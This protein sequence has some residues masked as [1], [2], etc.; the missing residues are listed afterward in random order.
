MADGRF[1]V[2]VVTAGD[3]VLEGDFGRLPIVRGETYACA[4]AL[5]HRLVA[6]ARRSSRSLHGAAVVTDEP[7]RRSGEEPSDGRCG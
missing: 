6:G 4:A 2:G 3:G 1:Y 5:D 7:D